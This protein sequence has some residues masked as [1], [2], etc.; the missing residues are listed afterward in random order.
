MAS[1]E[2][3]ADF[4]RIIHQAYALGIRKGYT[5]GRVDNRGTVILAFVI[6]AVMGI[7]AGLGVTGWL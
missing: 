6:G 3:D 4:K 2:T 1:N 7:V 5:D